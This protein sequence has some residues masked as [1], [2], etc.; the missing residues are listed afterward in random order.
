VQRYEVFL[1][2]GQLEKSLYD[3]SYSRELWSAE[4]ADAVTCVTC[5]PE[6]TYR[7]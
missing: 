3:T 4:L 7:L 6:A 2:E 1:D 5:T